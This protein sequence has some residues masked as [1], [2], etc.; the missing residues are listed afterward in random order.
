MNQSHNPYSPPKTEV[1]S[2]ELAAQ[3]PRPRAVDIA[4]VL[5]GLNVMLSLVGMLRSWEYVR[6]G[7][8]SGL[9]M[10]W[11]LLRLGLLVWICFAIVRGRNWARIL[12]AVL[13]VLGLFSLGVA[14]IALLKYDMRILPSLD[15]TVL[16][17][18]PSLLS[19]AAIY[20]LFVPGRS[21][22][23]KRVAAG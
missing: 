4:L 8:M 11:L 15:S 1:G 14:L 7:A 2:G 20:L 16:M 18:L 3:A 13:T 10:F 6:N 19:I 21:W 22:F 17:T 23:A 12:L 9:D 5:V